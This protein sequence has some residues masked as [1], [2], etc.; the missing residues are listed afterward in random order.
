MHKNFSSIS[1]QLHFHMKSVELF[2]YD[3]IRISAHFLSHML[4]IICREQVKG[5]IIT[6]V[7]S[8][9]GNATLDAFK[10]KYNQYRE[11]LL[12]VRLIKKALRG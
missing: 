2:L 10:N 6:F 11:F 1:E 9:R 12:G 5:V 4:K 7:P 3:S 8:R